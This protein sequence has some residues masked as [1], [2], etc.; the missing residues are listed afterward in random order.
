MKRNFTL[1]HRIGYPMQNGKN[2]KK[3]V[4]AWNDEQR[5]TGTFPRGEM[6]LNRYWT[7][8]RLCRERH[9]CIFKDQFLRLFVPKWIDL[10]HS[11]LWTTLY[12]P[13]VICMCN[14]PTACLHIYTHNFTGQGILFFR[15]FTWIISL[16]EELYIGLVVLT[17]KIRIN[18]IVQYLDVLKWL[19]VYCNL[20]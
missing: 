11:F 9:V 3:R 14:V 7:Q 17:Y 2:F 18:F 19:K 16:F 10:I 12:N 4:G 6:V 8:R 15:F 5:H 20:L 1:L 13:C